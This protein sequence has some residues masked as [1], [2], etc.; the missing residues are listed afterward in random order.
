MEPE[1]ITVL[2]KDETLGGRDVNMPIQIFKPTLSQTNAGAG[3]WPI[4]IF[5]HGRAASPQER[6][7]TQK[8]PVLQGHVRFWHAKGYAVIAPVRPGYGQSAADFPNYD[9]E[10]HGATWQGS[11]PNASCNGLANF[12]KTAAATLRATRAAHAWLGEQTWARKDRIVLVGQSVGGLTTVSACSAGLSGVSG[13]VNFA[14]G[15]GGYPTGSPGKSCQSDR[16]AAQFAEFGK[17]TVAPSLWLYSENDQYWGPDAPKQWHK[18]H[19][20]AQQAANQPHPAEFFMA[21]PVDPDG[22]A[23]LRAGGRHWAPVL[24]NWLKKHGL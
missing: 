22:H 7:D 2:V 1:I 9:P 5:S 23:L 17:T 20:E 4:V 18:A 6:I 3:P 14:G 12:A 24:N 16:L 8:T 13:C 11:A 19:L 10:H 15:S 21:P